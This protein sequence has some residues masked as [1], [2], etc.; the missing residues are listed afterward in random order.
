[1]TS[2]T[3]MSTRHNETLEMVTGLALLWLVPVVAFIVALFI[4]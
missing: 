2:T 3:S 1:M 4:G